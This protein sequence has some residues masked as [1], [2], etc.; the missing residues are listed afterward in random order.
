MYIMSQ[1]EVGKP[2][3]E[4]VPALAPQLRALALKGAETVADYI[5]VQASPSFPEAVKGSVTSD[6]GTYVS[7]ES[8]SADHAVMHMYNLT[9]KQSI[10]PVKVAESGEGFFYGLPTELTAAEARKLRTGL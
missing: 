10:L 1:Y 7:F 6:R 4:Q 5:E 2:Y 9:G 8:I 3:M